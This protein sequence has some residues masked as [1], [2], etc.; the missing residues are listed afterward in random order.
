M[1][2]VVHGP[3]FQ[4]HH[5]LYVGCLHV[6]QVHVRAPVL[7]SQRHFVQ[8]VHHVLRLQRTP[9]PFPHHFAAHPLEA[10]PCHVVENGPGPQHTRCVIVTRNSVGQHEAF[11]EHDDALSPAEWKKTFGIQSN[12]RAACCAV[13]S[14]VSSSTRFC[15]H[16]R[17]RSRDAWLRA[18]SSTRS[19]RHAFT[20]PHSPCAFTLV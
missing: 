20:N 8:K 9:L 10:P 7:T 14:S 12:S 1:D 3:C 6:T 15:F 16:T 2:R 11:P 13:A 17:V 4:F 18:S 19:R 5:G